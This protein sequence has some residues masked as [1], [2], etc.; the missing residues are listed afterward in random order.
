MKIDAKKKHATC[1]CFSGIW[2]RTIDITDMSRVLYRLSYSAVDF[3]ISKKKKFL[4]S[5]LKNNFVLGRLFLIGNFF[6]LR[7]PRSANQVP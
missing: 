5:V 6:N 1:A 3:H 7:V 2:D 4:S